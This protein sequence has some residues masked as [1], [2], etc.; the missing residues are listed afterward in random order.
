[1]ATRVFE[2]IKLFQELLKTTV[3]ETFLYYFIKIQL[4]SEK[5]MFE[6]KVNAQIDAWTDV[7]QNGT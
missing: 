3:A 7:L 4:V 1:M 5:K 2:G 6:E